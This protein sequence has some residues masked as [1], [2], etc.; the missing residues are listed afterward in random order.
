MG[1]KFGTAAVS[2]FPP[3]KYSIR[4][5]FDSYEDVAPGPSTVLQIIP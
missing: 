3:G 1:R 5:R 4:P 2:S